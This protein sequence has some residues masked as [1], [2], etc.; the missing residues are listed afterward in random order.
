M[1]KH[2][3]FDKGE[4]LEQRKNEFNEGIKALD[5]LE[6]EIRET[7]DRLTAVQFSSAPPEPQRRPRAR[8]KSDSVLPTAADHVAADKVAQQLAGRPRFRA[9]KS[10]GT[11][12]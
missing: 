7:L 6:S 12:T 1:S 4:V 5:R 2:A 11:L 8:K 9:D 10:S 3:F